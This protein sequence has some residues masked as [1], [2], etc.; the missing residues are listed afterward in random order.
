MP[1]ILIPFRSPE[2]PVEAFAADF[3][4]DLAVVDPEPVDLDLADAVLVVLLVAMAQPFRCAA[5]RR[6][7]ARRTGAPNPWG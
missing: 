5:L 3:T 1:V 7:P 4:D 2:D 6:A